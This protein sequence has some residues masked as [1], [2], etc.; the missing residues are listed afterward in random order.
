MDLVSPGTPLVQCYSNGGGVKN[1]FCFTQK[2]TVGAS[3]AP[4][5]D[6]IWNF[7]DLDTAHGKTACHTYD[8]AGT[9]TVSLTV[10]DT[11]GCS[12]ISIATYAITVLPDIKTGFT[13]S[14]KE[15]CGVST[16]TFLNKT[17]TA[18]A[19]ITK[20]VWDF[21]DLSPKDSTNW[22]PTHTYTSEGK[23]K[24]TLTLFNKLGC[25]ATFSSFAKNTKPKIKI[26]FDDTICWHNNKVTIV[27]DPMDDA[28]AEWNFGDPA[29][30]PDNFAISP[31]WTVSHNFKGG[32]KSYNVSVKVHHNVCG[33]MDTCFLVHITG[34]MA[35]IT[36]PGLP[37]PMSNAA[38]YV[39][40]KPMPKSEFLRIKLNA[41]KTDCEQKKMPYGY[42]V[43]NPVA[44]NHW[45]YKYCG[46][47]STMV[48]D[49]VVA[50]ADCAAPPFNEKAIY[51]KGVS[52]YAIYATDSVNLG[53]WKDSFLYVDT[54][55][56]ADAYPNL[57]I[58]YYYP[59]SG[60]KLPMTL[61]DSDL[62]ACNPPEHMVHFPNYT[63]K[64]RIYNALDNNPLAYLQTDF[65][66]TD[67]PVKTVFNGKNVVKLEK[68]DWTPFAGLL[69]GL[70]APNG[71]K[72]TCRNKTYP[73]ASD[74]LQYIWKF[75]DN[76]GVKC[77]STVSGI[78]WG[79]NPVKPGTK[80]EWC[81]NSTLP[82]PYHDYRDPAPAVG[83]CSEVLLGVWD[84]VTQCGDTAQ[85]FL[86]IGPPDAWYDRT[87]FC[88]MTWEMQTFIFR[89]KGQ[90]NNP[91][92][93]L[94]G[95]M[96]KNSF[97][98]AGNLYHFKL[99]LSEIIP[100]CGPQNYWLVF[101]SAA[102]TTIKCTDPSTG[103]KYKDY[104]FLGSTN[105]S[106]YPVGAPKSTWEN[107]PWMGNYW[108]MSGDTG[109]KTI[110]VVI[111][112]GACFDTAWYHDYICFNKL[113]PN[114]NINQ[115]TP[116]GSQADRFLGGS[117]VPQPFARNLMYF[118]TTRGRPELG[119]KEGIDIK[120]TPRDNNMIRVTKFTYQIDRTEYP[121]GDYYFAKPFFPD[122]T[123]L[124]PF[125]SYTD[126][127]TAVE[128]TFLNVKD[129]QIYTFLYNRITGNI[130][131]TIYMPK[132]KMVFRAYEIDSLNKRGHV[133]IPTNDFRARLL[134]F[135][136]TP[137]IT[138]Y[139]NTKPICIEGVSTI[140][141]MKD[142]TKDDTRFRGDGVPI[143]DT[144]RIH[145]PYPGPYEIL[146]QATN[147]DGCNDIGFHKLIYGHLARFNVKGGDS[148]ICLGD[149]VRFEKYIRYWTTACPPLPGSG[150]IPDFC[151]NGQVGGYPV[152]FTPWD[153]NPGSGDFT[154]YRKSILPSWKPNGNPQPETVWWNFGDDQV[155]RRIPGNT[156][157]AYVYKKPGIY[158]VTMASVDSMGIPVYTTRK[159]FIKVISLKPD[160]A[161]TPESDTLK[162]CAPQQVTLKD[163]TRFEGTQVDVPRKFG[164]LVDRVD[165]IQVKVPKKTVHIGRIDKTSGG[166][167]TL[168][169]KD[170]VIPEH[171]EWIPALVKDTM[172]IDSVTFVTW[173][174]GDGRKITK[175][176]QDTGIIDYAK[177][178]RYDVRLDVRSQN[179][180]INSVQKPGYINIS[181]PVPN[182]FIDGDTAGCRPF[183]VKLKNVSDTSKSYEW[184]WGDGTTSS[185]GTLEDVIT[186]TYEKA[187]TFEITVRQTE[188]V[189]NIYTNKDEQCTAAWPS[190]KD[191]FIHFIVVVYPY[192]PLSIG[193]DRNACKNDP[194]KFTA[195]SQ[196]GEYKFFE[197]DMG[198][199][200]KFKTTDDSTYTY[201][202]YK[203]GQYRVIVKG[204]TLEK[205]TTSDTMLLTVDSVRADFSIDTTMG[206]IAKFGFL[207]QSSNAVRYHWDFG[208]GQTMETTDTSTFLH[209]YTT[210]L[211]S[212]DVEGQDYSKSFTVTLR[213][214]SPTGC[215]DSIQKVVTYSKMWKHYNVFTPNGDGKNDAF[216]PRI[217]GETDYKLQVYNRWGE[218][219]FE[220]TASQT[221]WNG[222]NMNTGKPCPAGTYFYVWS[223]KLVG[224]PV[225]KTVTGT[226]D[227]IR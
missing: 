48:E 125:R 158:T 39:D 19:Y 64:W 192:G 85:M 57:N 34:P 182:F 62:F 96:M 175:Y 180:C 195:S 132:E 173:Y 30:G 119:R 87:A 203:A 7:G 52:N 183:T 185:T 109:C 102:A 41:T 59:P 105:K 106:G 86:K 198:N 219:V 128:D 135:Q 113:D 46:T 72:D 171:M 33:E 143:H 134:T 83:G 97:S 45:R 217:K 205:C 9:Y 69:A 164:Y 40:A 42:Y 13:I 137:T 25:S 101:D 157:I 140:V 50:N 153:S 27:M 118:E 2:S 196:N 209:V 176:A 99:D 154:K 188:I 14:G 155:M 146:T 200:D 191:S 84:P 88:T 226:V 55:K 142:P 20:W 18:S 227:L 136:C 224:G 23:F 73:W 193:P 95:F 103:Y 76:L 121:A 26:N 211:P 126:S 207:N 60:Q 70:G 29:S 54:F 82:N 160:F 110:G 35:I 130:I 197:W 194:V 16:Y 80:P 220:S 129:S 92:R 115:F 122:T 127:I 36:M 49:S 100:V 107:I 28:Y 223:F 169:R 68:G 56:A 98:C 133:T 21:G 6:Y 184:I 145:L 74:S 161:A 4:I 11:N 89:A 215:I 71:W 131:D 206:M 32:P 114:F 44:T 112:N 5:I 152:I 66:Q 168:I 141:K 186:H 166:C 138:L 24:V 150:I 124:K 149:T 212:A 202:Y 116:N 159:N 8:S 81:L 10:I 1:K 117:S 221:D 165:S 67:V 178:G 156:E 58:Q 90:P 170:S 63:V 120:L 17:D 38:N 214:Y 199:G 77:T 43:K 37:I 61:H 147:L 108:W 167:G 174:P 213:A 139:T 225:D 22:S 104:G 148:I 190:E 91:N 162:Y 222:N 12:D 181:G 189:H 93:P 208:D 31:E 53:V 218:K 78:V 187:G 216:D 177:N 111:Q 79:S 210:N 75:D 144:V 163:L 94:R 123:E 172:F 51:E 204:T 65:M 179:Q 201:T 15:Q 151:I 47:N 3:G